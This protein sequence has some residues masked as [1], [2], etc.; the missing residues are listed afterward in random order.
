MTLFWMK[1]MWNNLVQINFITQMRVVHSGKV[2]EKFKKQTFLVYLVKIV[3]QES[4]VFT[5]ALSVLGRQ[6]IN[7]WW[8][9]RAL[10]TYM[11][12]KLII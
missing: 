1:M 9:A 5:A 6:S 8:A 11:R 10:Q 4:F 7:V 2:R 3:C 12:T